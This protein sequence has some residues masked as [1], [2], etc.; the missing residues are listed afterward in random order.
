MMLQHP[1]EIIEQSYTLLFFFLHVSVHEPCLD[2]VLGNVK[3]K[4][5]TGLATIKTEDEE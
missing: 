4:I 5:I 2:E 3:G 1:K